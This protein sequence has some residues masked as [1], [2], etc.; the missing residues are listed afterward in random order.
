MA[1]D[2]RENDERKRGGAYY[3]VHLLFLPRVLRWFFQECDNRIDASPDNDDDDFAATASSHRSWQNKK[4]KLFLY[5]FTLTQKIFVSIRRVAPNIPAL[6]M[7]QPHWLL[8][9]DPSHYLSFDTSSLA[10]LPRQRESI[11]WE[12]DDDHRQTE[13]RREGL[14]SLAWFVSRSR[15][16]F[17]S[18]VSELPNDAVAAAAIASRPEVNTSNKKSQGNLRGLRLKSDC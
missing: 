17:H 16:V 6:F 13:W 5:I 12:D 14:G 3:Y 1:D 18:L 15:I 8:G 7:W 4:G 2:C 9:L 10:L 11:I